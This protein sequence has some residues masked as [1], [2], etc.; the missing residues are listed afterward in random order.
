LNWLGCDLWLLNADSKVIRK[1][2]YW[3][4]FGGE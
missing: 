4:Y 3:K 2:T 1:D